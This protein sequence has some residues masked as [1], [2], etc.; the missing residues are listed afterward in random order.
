MVPPSGPPAGDP[1]RPRSASADA[2]DGA[3]GP[4]VGNVLG[5]SLLF[6]ERKALLALNR[7]G[8]S[9]GVRVRDYEAE[10]PNVAFPLKGALQAARFRHRRCRAVSSSCR[11]G[12]R[13]AAARGTPATRSPVSG[14]GG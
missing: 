13:P 12:T 6:R 1:P 9:P 7:R 2:S 14:S 3:E 10:I 8:L 11:A 4:T 5:F